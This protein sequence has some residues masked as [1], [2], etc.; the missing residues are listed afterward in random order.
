MEPLAKHVPT[1]AGATPSAPLPSG[2]SSR[3]CGT[4]RMAGPTPPSLD[5][6]T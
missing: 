3:F 5:C 6:I 1:T 4:A 2:L